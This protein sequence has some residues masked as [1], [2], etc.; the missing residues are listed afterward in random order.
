MPTC[1]SLMFYISSVFFLLS[2]KCLVIANFHLKSITTFLFITFYLKNLVLWNISDVYQDLFSFFQQLD[3]IVWVNRSHVTL[4]RY[5]IRKFSLSWH[6]H[7]KGVL[8]NSLPLRM[9][10]MQSRAWGN[11]SASTKIYLHQIRTRNLKHT[12]QTF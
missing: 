5:M 1:S 4:I 11:D 12:T 9:Q 3:H 8:C 10:R 7:Q 2:N 6:F